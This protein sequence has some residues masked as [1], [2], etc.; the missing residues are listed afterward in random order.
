MFYQQIV[1]DTLQ[2]QKGKILDE[3]DVI[4]LKDYMQ[5]KSNL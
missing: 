1:I 3:E 2:L 5:V 4:T